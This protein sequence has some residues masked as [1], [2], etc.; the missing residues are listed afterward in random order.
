VSLIVASHRV[1][2]DLIN[3]AVSKALQAVDQ[4]W[5][6]PNFLQAFVVCKVCLD[7]TITT[8]SFSRVQFFLFCKEISLPALKT[9]TP[10]HHHST[11]QASYCPIGL[12]TTIAVIPSIRAC[13]HV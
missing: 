1:Q 4:L 13:T 2:F 3:V 11:Q 12:P 7:S 5:L 9:A 6:T 10:R 8:P